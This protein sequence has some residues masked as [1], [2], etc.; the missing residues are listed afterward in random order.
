MLRYAYVVL[1]TLVVRLRGN[2]TV[3]P[4]ADRALTE[5]RSICK[6]RK[7]MFFIIMCF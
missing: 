3:T 5:L 6:Q 4:C 2:G 7:V 1:F